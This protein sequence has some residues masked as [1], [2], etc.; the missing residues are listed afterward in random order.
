MA[1]MRLLMRDRPDQIRPAPALAAPP[2]RI[3][4]TICKSPPS[5]TH[6]GLTPFAHQRN[7]GLIQIFSRR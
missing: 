5:S 1:P 2:L 6:R 7:F 4:L 3:T